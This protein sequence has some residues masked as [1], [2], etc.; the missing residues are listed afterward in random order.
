[1][2]GYGLVGYVYDLAIMGMVG[3]LEGRVGLR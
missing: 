2:N 1:M 3:C